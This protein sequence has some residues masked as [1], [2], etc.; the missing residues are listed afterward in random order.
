MVARGGRAVRLRRRRSNGEGYCQVLPAAC[1]FDYRLRCGQ[2][3][4]MDQ[5]RGSRSQWITLTETAP[6]GNP[7]PR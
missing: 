1:S 4:P 7:F 5:P 6:W 3:E 2:P